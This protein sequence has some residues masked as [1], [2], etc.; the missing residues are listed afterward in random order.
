MELYYTANSPAG[1][2]YISVLVKE[3]H[4]NGPQTDYGPS[5][6]HANYDHMH[7][8]RGYVTN[9]WGDMIPNPTMGSTVT[10][11]YTMT[12]P[13]GWNVANCR[14]VAFSEKINGV[15]PPS[16]VVLRRNN[17][18]IGELRIMSI[19][20]GV[21]GYTARE[22]VSLIIRCYGSYIVPYEHGCTSGWNSE[23]SE[24]YAGD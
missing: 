24:W 9:T 2:D 14:V 7:V 17:T 16:D 18:V 15:Y 13:A 22:T 21:Q 12:I 11:S 23:M 19:L 1:D 3:D 8:L 6:D 4:L 5:G 10:R 20:V